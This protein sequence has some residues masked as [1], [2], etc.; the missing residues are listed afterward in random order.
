MYKV[1]KNYWAD[2]I[3]EKISENEFKN[4]IESN[5][6]K[7]CFVG[8]KEIKNFNIS[9]KEDRMYLSYGLRKNSKKNYYAN[10]LNH[11]IV[12]KNDVVV[13]LQDKNY[14]DFK[15]RILNKETINILNS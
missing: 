7:K 5:E 2:K 11:S 6:I 15:E 1:I 14:D 8:F 12:L 9:I 4:H 13:F 10:F 3:Q